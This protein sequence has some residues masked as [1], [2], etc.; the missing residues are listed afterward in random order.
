MPA[1]F[2]DG[3]GREWLV[4]IHAWGIK[5]VRQR[6]GVNLGTLHQNGFAPLGEL[7][8]DVEKFVDV[9]YVLCAEQAEKRGVSDEQFGRSITGDAG[10]DA[11]NAFMGAYELFCPADRRAVFRALIGK[12]AEVK[13]AIVETALREIAA[14]D[15]AE[16][17]RKQIS[18]IAA[19]SSPAS[20]AATPGG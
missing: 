15:A 12:N 8:G 11:A 20:S 2:R 13:G 19:S 18:T 4:E 3:A 7:L 10:E 6:T 17:A 14:I 1:T 9:L 16:A 5:Q